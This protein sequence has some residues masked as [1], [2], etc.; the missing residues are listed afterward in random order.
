VGSQLRHFHL[1]DLRI[2]GTSAAPTGV[3]AHTDAVNGIEADPSRPD[4]IATF[5]RT[6]GEP[7]KLWDIRRMGTSVGEIKTAGGTVSAMQWSRLYPGTLSVAV[8]DTVQH[9]DTIASLSRPVLDRL[10]HA[11]SVVLDLALYP[12]PHEKTTVFMGKNGEGNGEN[13]NQEIVSELYQNR[14]LVVLADKSV[15]DMPKDTTAP[16]AISRRDGSL[17]HAFGGALWI[18]SSSK[19]PCAMENP[20]AENNEDISARM[21]RRAKCSRTTR[22][23]MDAAL[24]L[25]MLS[26]EEDNESDAGDS[27]DTLPSVRMLIRLWSWIERIERFCAQKEV[28]GAEKWPAKGLADSGVWRLLELDRPVANGGANKDVVTLDESLSMDVHDSPARR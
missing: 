25:Q 10:S 26:E 11:E 17:A 6:A 7:V 27:E 21:M 16:L 20:E 24:N 19:G 5:G 3:W 22:Y 28:Y 14:M 15:Q 8:G 12:K 13:F 2:S 1:Y 18:E 23:S 4:I 9:Y